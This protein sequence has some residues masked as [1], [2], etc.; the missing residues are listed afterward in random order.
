MRTVHPFSQTATTANQ[1]SFDIDIDIDIN[2]P[3]NI[4]FQH[5]HAISI[6]HSI[7]IQN[8]NVCP[9][10]FLLLSYLTNSI[11]SPALLLSRSPGLPLFPLCLPRNAHLR[12]FTFSP[13]PPLSKPF[14]SHVHTVPPRSKAAPVSGVSDAFLVQH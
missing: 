8:Q 4:S 9:R 5:M 12:L 13:S 2:N 7:N 3:N 11:F 6:L 10:P 1:N 14:I